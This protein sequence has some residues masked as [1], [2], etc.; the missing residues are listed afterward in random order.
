MR[1]W[2]RTREVTLLNDECVKLVCDCGEVVE[3]RP[4]PIRSKYP[5][6][7]WCGRGWRAVIEAKE[8]SDEQA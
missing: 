2:R 8:P 6:C 7:Q 5:V 4:G 3:F 1:R